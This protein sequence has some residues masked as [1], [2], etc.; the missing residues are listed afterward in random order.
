[1]THILFKTAV[2][3]RRTQVP[4]FRADSPRSRPGSV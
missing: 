2:S 1:L 4:P 3:A